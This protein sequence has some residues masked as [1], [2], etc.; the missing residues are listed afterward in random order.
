MVDKKKK[1]NAWASAVHLYSKPIVT[2]NTLTS[3]AIN[4]SATAKLVEAMDKPDQLVVFVG[5]G[6]SVAYGQ[7]DWT[8]L[9]QNVV[10]RAMSCKARSR[11]ASADD[12]RHSAELKNL[13]ETLQKIDLRESTENKILAL[14]LAGRI[15]EVLTPGKSPEIEVEIRG[16]KRRIRS[17]KEIIALETKGWENFSW[18]RTKVITKAMMNNLHT[19]DFSDKVFSS[20]KTIEHLKIVV[21]KY[22]LH[23]DT[24][25][26]KFLNNCIEWIDKYREKSPVFFRQD[27]II[28]AIY[29]TI[30]SIRLGRKDEAL[31]SSII[32]DINEQILAASTG[33]VRDDGASHDAD[34]ESLRYL[35]DPIRSLIDSLN[36]RRFITTNYDREI[37]DYFERTGYTF[38]W[39]DRSGKPSEALVYGKDGTGATIRSA[40]LTEDSVA[41]LVQFAAD[42]GQNATDVFHLHGRNDL[43]DS[44]I[45]TERDY[46]QVYLHSDR[47]KQL[48]EEALDVVFR[49]NTILFVGLGMTEEDLLRPLRKFGV[50]RPEDRSGDSLIVLMPQI[51]ADSE[52]AA[53]RQLSLKVRYGV[54]TIIYGGEELARVLERITEL[55]KVLKSD[56]AQ[57]LSGNLEPLVTKKWPGLEAHIEALNL[58]T[59]LFRESSERFPD[60][61]KFATAN[62]K[63]GKSLN[64][65]LHQFIDAA[66]ARVTTAS[67]C[68]FLERRSKHSRDDFRLRRLAP[69]PRD[70]SF[71]IDKPFAVRHGIVQPRK[72]GEPPEETGET[73]GLFFKLAQ[74]RFDALRRVIESVST[75]SVGAKKGTKQK[76]QRRRIFL[77]EGERGV[78]KGRTFWRLHDRKDDGNTLLAGGKRYEHAYSATT[79]FS[80]EFASTFDKLIDFLG[81]GQ[82]RDLHESRPEKLLRALSEAREKWKTEKDRRLF[83]LNG[84]DN[85]LDRDGNPFGDE[86]AELFRILLGPNASDVPFDIILLNDA[87]ERTREFLKRCLCGLHDAEVSEAAQ[88]YQSVFEPPSGSP[89]KENKPSPKEAYEAKVGRWIDNPIEIGSDENANEKAADRIESLAKDVAI[90]ALALKPVDIPRHYRQLA[91]D[92]HDAANRTMRYLIPEKHTNQGLNFPD[93]KPAATEKGKGTAKEVREDATPFT[94]ATPTVPSISDDAM[95]EGG[96]AARCYRSVRRFRNTINHTFIWSMVE[97]A[98]KW[99]YQDTEDKADGAAL[100]DATEWL[101]NLTYRLRGLDTTKRPEACCSAVIDLYERHQKP[102]HSRLR[103]SILKHL[104]IIGVPVEA[105]VLARC[106]ELRDEAN[107]LLGATA[108]NELREKAIRKALEDLVN[109]HLIF[110]IDNEMPATEG[111]LEDPRTTLPRFAVHRLTQASIFWRMGCPRVDG[112][113]TNFFQVTLYAAQPKDLPSL[114]ADSY[115]FVRRLTESLLQ[116]K[117]LFLQDTDGNQSDKTRLLY[118]IKNAVRCHRAAFGAVRASWSLAVLSRLLE[119]TEDRSAEG[120]GLL[121]VYKR[122]NLALIDRAKADDLAYEGLGIDDGDPEH[123]PLRALYADEIVWL[124]NELGVTALTQGRPLDALPLFDNAAEANANIEHTKENATWARVTLN[125]AIAMIE[126]GELRHAR[127]LLD[128]IRIY[129][130]RRIKAIGRDEDESSLVATL[131]KGYLALIDHLAGRLNEADRVY[132]NVIKVLSKHERY[133]AVAIFCRHRS[134]L[135]AREQNFD[136]AKS[137]INRSIRAAQAGRHQDILHLSRVNQCALEFGGKIERLVEADAWMRSA[138]RYADYMG[139]PKLKVEVLFNRGRVFLDRGETKVAGECATKALAIASHHGM[140]LRKI[141]ALVLLGE[142]TL[143]RDNRDSA[144]QIFITAQRLAEEVGYHLKG[145]AAHQILLR[146]GLHPQ[147]QLQEL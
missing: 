113:E 14:E 104:T 112:G 7:I 137:L 105:G 142:V 57:P 56:N 24:E 75:G 61:H 40:V 144:R 90:I 115:Q 4:E 125:A 131:A 120:R 23:E 43:P 86:Y 109:L 17:L 99:L 106:P 88:R 21:E 16:E 15:V 127:R 132:K 79:S 116:E 20:Q 103:S 83:V 138:D 55:R 33:S 135:K 27:L 29:F 32:E 71:P 12:H 26:P 35:H 94:H 58:L 28:A 18:D 124:Y 97:R 38:D 84:I 93:P 110:Q 80:W 117:P 92:E 34:S 39:P 6:T 133:R 69:E 65:L 36:V 102:L 52:E 96:R 100:V 1:S 8:T 108:T 122:R 44:I 3:E 119:E 111:E 143:E 114:N 60:I 147:R 13:K 82:S 31:E 126:V 42:A 9:V 50:E 68:K 30:N 46:Q 146:K 2:P 87:S 70:S 11:S 85:L 73:K 145:E 62:D 89:V 25:I 118:Q 64:R 140:K 130:H 53:Q 123:K 47:R 98:I 51:S 101:D 77:I 37:E 141:A 129:E 5:S 134:T 67:L 10:D 63:A 49:A 74:N 72:S 139:I 136:A 128:Q 76:E 78:G 95:A 19:E 91:K 121:E 81:N 41:D 22:S 59:H 66:A 48:F 54:D 45:A 107:T